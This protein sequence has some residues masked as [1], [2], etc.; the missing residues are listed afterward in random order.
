MP[1]T[2]DEISALYAKS[3]ADLEPPERL[4]AGIR[5]AARAAQKT[6]YR[7]LYPAIGLA[8]TLVIGVGVAWLHIGVPPQ[9]SAPESIDEDTAASVAAPKVMPPATTVAPAPV[10]PSRATISDATPATESVPALQRFKLQEAD[11]LSPSAISSGTSLGA[12]TSRKRAEPTI[13][14]AAGLEDAGR[15]TWEK[16]IE[17]ASEAENETL[18]HCLKLEYNRRF[19]GPV[20]DGD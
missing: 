18:V 10:Q 14:C 12:L 19:P 4:D 13:Q 17:E 15:E 2:D 9:L 1:D 6:R 7:R 11:A 3:K 20:G 16:A 8:A 5:A